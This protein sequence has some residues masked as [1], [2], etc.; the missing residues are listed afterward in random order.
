MTPTELQ[1]LALRELLL[2]EVYAAAHAWWVSHRPTGWDRG[3]HLE[4]PRINTGYRSS[5][6]DL[7]E[8]VAAIDRIEGK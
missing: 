6:P 4:N 1:Q 7:A 8:A 2:E 5:A 3:M